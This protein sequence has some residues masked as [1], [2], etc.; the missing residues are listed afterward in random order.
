MNSA[1]YFHFCNF[2]LFLYHFIFQNIQ[3]LHHRLKM[4]S[5]DSFL[6]VIEMFVSSSS[7]NN[8]L[9]IK[10]KLHY[11]CH[12][13][14]HSHCKQRKKKVYHVFASCAFLLCIQCCMCVCFCCVFFFCLLNNSICIVGICSF[15]FLE[16]IGNLSFNK[17]GVTLQGKG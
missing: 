4:H 15:R 2:L 11:S 17:N 14:S 3:N 13:H 10:G 9:L 16:L 1:L 7:S 6:I 5:L 8:R 12:A